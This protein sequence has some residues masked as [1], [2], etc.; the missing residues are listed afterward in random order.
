MLSRTEE[1]IVKNKGEGGPGIRHVGC[2]AVLKS[3]N[4]TEQ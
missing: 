3:E 2:C 1:A 4:M